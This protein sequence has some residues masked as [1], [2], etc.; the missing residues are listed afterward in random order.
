ML[1]RWPHS[2]TPDRLG[3]VGIQAHHET[4]DMFVD[5]VNRMHSLWRVRGHNCERAEKWGQQCRLY[6][7]ETHCSCAYSDIEV[8]PPVVV[9]VCGQLPHA[10]QLQ[11]CEK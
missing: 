7:Q 4:G 6:D 2:E 5:M 9:V 8:R 3:S 11:G 1:N 10:P